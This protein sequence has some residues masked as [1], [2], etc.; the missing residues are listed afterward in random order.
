MTACFLP[1]L[2]VCA[3]PSRCVEARC[4]SDPAARVRA[5]RARRS[6]AASSLS[7]AVPPP[8]PQMR[9]CSFPP[10]T[11]KGDASLFGGAGVLQIA[12]GKPVSAESEEPYAVSLQ[13]HL[14]G[15]EFPDTVRWGRHRRYCRKLPPQCRRQP[16]PPP[17]PAR[18]RRS[19]CSRRACS[20][21][22]PRPRNV[23]AAAG[24][25]E[26]AATRRWLWWRQRQRKRRQRRAFHVP[27]PPPLSPCHATS[28]PPNLVLLPQH[29]LQSTT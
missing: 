22:T 10:Q 2:S 14:L 24:G 29:F 20:T 25:D 16:L 5:R 6:S 26:A 17:A 4:V 9:A 18:A 11:G 23:R 15:Y 12:H 19:C 13:K 3:P 27:P 21:R 8:S 1:A 7:A 28:P